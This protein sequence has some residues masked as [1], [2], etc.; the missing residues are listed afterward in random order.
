MKCFV[1]L[2]DIFEL[3]CVFCLGQ[4]L[5]VLLG[6]ILYNNISWRLVVVLLFYDLI[7]DNSSNLVH[8]HIFIEHSFPHLFFC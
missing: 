2:Y 8:S 7:K 6:S 3:I 5:T 1:M 4:Q